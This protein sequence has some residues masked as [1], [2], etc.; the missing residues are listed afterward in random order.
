MSALCSIRSR[1]HVPCSMLHAQ[2][3]RVQCS[4][5]SAQGSMLSAHVSQPVR[6]SVRHQSSPQPR[7]HH[8][9]IAAL[10][11]SVPIFDSIFRIFLCVFWVIFFVV[12]TFCAC[13]ALSLPD[14]TTYFISCRMGPLVERKRKPLQVLK[15]CLVSTCQSLFSPCRC[16]V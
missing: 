2:C 6:P 12:C 8:S 5:L 11:I 1:F 14:P 16:F 10:V 15:S 4:Q 9:S 7:T 3:L 13:V